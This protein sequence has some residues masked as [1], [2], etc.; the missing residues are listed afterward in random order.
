MEFESKQL[1]KLVLDFVADEGYSPMK[2]K[3]I[4]KQ[5]KLPLEAQRVLRKTIKKLV[6][7]GRLAYGPNHF[8]CRAADGPAGRTEK[9]SMEGTFK[10]NA[11]GFGFVRPSALDRS[12]GWSD[13]VYVSAKNS[14]DASSGDRVRVK[15]SRTT[16]RGVRGRIVEIIE[17][18]TNQF[19]GALKQRKRSCEVAV[20]GKTFNHPVPVGDPTAKGALVGDKVVIE[21][22]RFPSERDAGEGVII[23]VLGPR[24]QPGVDTLSIIREYNL[25]D[26]FPEPVLED[27]RQQ[28]EQFNPDEVEG[29]VDWTRRTTITIDPVDAR[30]FDDAISLR[31]L[32][33]GH[34]ELA[35][36]IA[37]VAHFVPARTDLDSEARERGTSVYLPDRVIPMLPELISNNLASLQPDRKRL[38]KTAVMEFT[39]EGLPVAAEVQ[40]SVILSDRRF[41]YEEVDD[42]LAT[43]QLWEDKLSPQ[44]HEMLGWMHKL[45]MCL[46]RRRQ[47]NGALELSL[48]AT[49]IELDRRGEVKGAHYVEH[50]V[51]HQIIEEFML[52][53]NEAVA[54]WLTD[55]GL[56]FLRRVHEPP[57]LK[58]LKALTSFVRGLGLECD[59][60]E[61]RFEI[62]RL[63]DEVAQS[64]QEPAI[65]FA[66]LKSMQ[67]AVYSPEEE[68]HYALNSKHYCH[69]T[70]PIRRYP[71]LTV[72]RLV[73]DVLG[74]RK[75]TIHM[76][77]LF[78]L[79]EHCS[80]RERRAESAERELVKLKLLSLL[81]KNIGMQLEAIITGVEDYGFYAQGVQLPAEGLVRVSELHDDYYHFDRSAHALEGR[82][83]D[84]RF[85]LGDMV[86]V[87]VQ[88]VDIERR[89]LDLAFVERLSNDKA[90]HR[91]DS[92]NSYRMP[93]GGTVAE[94]SGGRNRLGTKAPRGKPTTKGKPKGKGKAKS[95]SKGKGKA[96]S[97]RKSPGKGGKGRRR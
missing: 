2:P 68:G 74:G 42:Y 13:D 50:T 33:N 37:D 19:V 3:S 38:T 57:S 59:S 53:A 14:A 29:R 20:D 48:P 84:S 46:R 18:A 54:R 47:S 81:A 22:V 71:D 45:A 65:N 25:P 10:R 27:S 79:G 89:L 91:G 94:P 21:M 31:A 36:H 60:L 61:S 62:Q 72:H 15:V 1:E 76:E 67:K 86:V 95:K 87:E 77:A 85:Q 82:R 28:A 56:A 51:S 11:G 40:N 63:L 41:T 96:K 26:D 24:N 35:V 78:G 30:D 88:R 34:W 52:A 8:V 39:Q 75:P 80:D 66:V 17:R 16:D 58:K 69:F 92:T 43:P 90:L 73:N 44:T 32:E 97:R 55:K 9:Q 6:K 70:S 93:K 49:K 5:L 12:N 4:G 23:E 64:P 7:K 83:A